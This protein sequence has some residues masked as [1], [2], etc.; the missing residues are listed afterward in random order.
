MLRLRYMFTHIK[1][2]LF[3]LFSWLRIKHWLWNLI[4]NIV[5]I[6]TFVSYKYIFA[7]AIHWISF[8][9]NIAW[10]RLVG[11]LVETHKSRFMSWLNLWYF[12]E[13]LIHILISDF[14]FKQKFRELFKYMITKIISFKYW[15]INQTL[16]KKKKNTKCKIIWKVILHH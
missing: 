8:H 9:H 15:L 7:I 11:W 2:R 4:Y 6:F 16:N 3:G 14:G 5:Y 10:S 12:V 1:L 13:Y